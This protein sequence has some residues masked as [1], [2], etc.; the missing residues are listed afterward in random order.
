MNPKMVLAMAA[1]LAC[2]VGCMK[3]APVTQ[4]P[5]TRGGVV[6][7]FYPT[8]YFASRIAG[9]LTPVECPLP[10][11]EDPAT[12]EPDDAAM[13]RYQSAAL[14][15]VNGASFEEWVPRAP[16]PRSRVVDTTAGVQEQLLRHEQSVTHSHGMA[17]EHSHE[18]I[19]G[20][21]WLDPMM[22]MAQAEA[23]RDAMVA[24]FP[25]HAVSFRMNAQALV[26]DLRSLDAEL[27]AMNEAM[28]AVT[29]ICSHPAYNYLGRR[30]GWN[31]VI[32]ALDPEVE[33]T[34][35]AVREL[36]HA[37]EKAGRCVVLWE[38]PTSEANERAIREEI[39]AACVLYSPCEHEPESGDFLTVM[40]ANIARLRATIQP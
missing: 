2:V 26:A 10:A 1:T 11:D 24:E 38:S 17:G 5:G 19:D 3:E 16:L 9:G 25:E 29:V 27:R 20:H 23:I 28:Q 32:V 21:T 34:V 31:L 39:G 37:A 7:T 33:L 14:V 22:S 8:T 12:W 18:G 36:G 30:Y 40:R 6:T 15:V 35:D 13:K 4:T